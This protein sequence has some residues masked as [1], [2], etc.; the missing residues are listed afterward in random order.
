VSPHSKI[1]LIAATAVIPVSAV[2]FLVWT[3]NR[4]IDKN[5]GKQL[6]PIPWARLIF[7]A[8]V[9]LIASAV[10]CLFGCGIPSVPSCG[11]YHKRDTDGNWCAECYDAHGDYAKCRS[12]EPLP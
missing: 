1:V 2:S 5:D 8:S 11:A 10:C 3:I 4:D 6:P 12:T 7:A 9:T